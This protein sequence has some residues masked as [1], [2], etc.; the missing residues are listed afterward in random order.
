[1]CVVA[2]R[3]RIGVQT[4]QRR[5]GGLDGMCRES[6]ARRVGLYGPVGV[7]VHTARKVWEVV[8]KTAKMVDKKSTMFYRS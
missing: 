1:M 3:K 8:V 2:G 6:E 5:G 4:L 7:N